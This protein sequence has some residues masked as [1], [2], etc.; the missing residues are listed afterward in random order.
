[1]GRL[2][3]GCGIGQIPSSYQDLVHSLPVLF[4]SGFL[5]GSFCGI[6]GHG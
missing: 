5:L 1:M 2:L 6:F 4:A 3:E